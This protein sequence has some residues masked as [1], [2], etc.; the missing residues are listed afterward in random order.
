VLAIEHNSFQ[1]K[2]STEGKFM[3]ACSS[4]QIILFV[5]SVLWDLGVPQAAETLLYEDN[6]ACIAM[7]NAKKKKTANLT[8]GY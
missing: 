5:C 4:G 3:A 7:A 8:Y 2:S 6:D 1:Q